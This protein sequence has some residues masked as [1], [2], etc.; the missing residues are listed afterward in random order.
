MDD[1]SDGLRAVGALAHLRPRRSLRQLGP[2]ARAS[3]LLQVRM[4]VKFGVRQSRLT[5]YHRDAMRR[6]L[7]ARQS[8]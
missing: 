7:L 3:T 1:L 4:D 6:Q 5:N 2:V 8:L